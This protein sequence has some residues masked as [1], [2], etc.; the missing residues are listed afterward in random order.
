MSPFVK[1]PV[2]IRVRAIT[3]RYAAPLI[4]S[5]N[6]IDTHNLEIKILAL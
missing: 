5:N 3:E 4:I 6:E 2:A 1:P